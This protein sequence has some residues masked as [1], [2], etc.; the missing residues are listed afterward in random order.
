MIVIAREE[1]C[2]VAEEKQFEKKVREFLNSL[3][4]QWHFKVFGNA[5]QESGIP[6]LLG[7]LSGRLVALEVKSSKGKPSELQ[8]YKIDL[9]NKA[10]GYATVV[11][12]KN[13]EEVKSKLIKIS[14]GEWFE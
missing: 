8:I 3:P 6:D 11:S 1:R 10:G 5:F 13:W 7:C 2:L 14:E 9:I 12:P 4:V